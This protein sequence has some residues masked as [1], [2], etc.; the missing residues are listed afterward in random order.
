MKHLGTILSGISLLILII[1]FNSKWGSI[2]PLGKLLSPTHGYLI[3]PELQGI[4]SGF[5]M[6]ELGG[7][8]D[9]V[10][11]YFDDRMVPHIFA[12]NDEDAYFVQGYLHA[13][14]RLWQMEFQTHFAAG[15][16]SEIVGEKALVVDRTN[17]RLGMVYAAEKSLEEM[18]KDTLSF[19]AMNAYTAGVN[20]YIGTLEEKDLPL[21]YKILDYQPEPWS[22]LKSAL[23]SKYMAKDLAGY[24]DDFE[25]TAVIATMGKEIFDL[26]YPN[27]EDS[28]DP[29]IPKAFIPPFGKLTIQA[30]HDSSYFHPPMP[31]LIEREKPDKANGSNNWAL[32]GSKTMTGRPILCNDPHLKLRLPSIWYEIQ[33]TTPEYSCYGVSIPGA[34]GILIGFNEYVAFGSTNAMR[35]VMDYYEITFRD[36][37][38]SQ[39]LYNGRWESTSSRIETYVIRDAKTQADTVFYTHFGPVVYDENFRGLKN[40]HLRSNAGKFYA[41][42]WKAHDP[43]NDIVSF[44]LLDRAKNYD[45]YRKAIARFSCPGQNLIFASASGDIAITQQGVF[46]A[47][48]RYQGEFIMEGKDSLYEWQ[49]MIPQDQVLTMKNPERGFVSSANQLPADPKEYP[50]FLGGDY[51]YER[52]YRINQ[53]LR[54]L[55]KA[56][57]QD[58]IDLQND[59][60]NIRAHQIRGLLIETLK[61]RNFTNE[62]DSYFHI[63]ERWNLY[64]DSASEGAT[65]YSLLMDRLEQRIWGDELKKSQI[66]SMPEHSTLIQNLL[67][68]INF[69]CVDN[70]L[71]PQVET[72][73]E[74]LSAA[75]LSIVPVLDELKKVGRLTWGKYKQTCVP[76]LMDI[77]QN[78]SS[79]SRLDLNVGGGDGIVNATKKSHGPSWKMIVSLTSPVEAWGV[80]PGGQSGHPGNPYYDTGVG[81]W[82]EGKYFKL[83]FMK[84]FEKGS[85]KII[86]TLVFKP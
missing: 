69:A 18:E 44:L 16:L 53:I 9:S 11:V 43:S 19:L 52:G 71:T 14:D 4:Q 62:A 30:V 59:N 86:Q 45:D 39:Y 77:K 74:Q 51:V 3:D 35:D 81:P 57:V 67:R 10:Q 82:S 8:K 72:F 26:M 55:Q 1:L 66:G 49:G 12:S 76:H 56:T 31:D 83:W 32:A 23:L 34:P 65:V 50:Y 24:D 27:R 48:W 64:N 15:R 36:K 6:V 78:M 25:R 29:I 60:F 61:K 38:K 54:K 17:R 46:P 79:L 75:F 13:R 73:D 80:Y 5:S 22:N 47:K 2:P 42:R 20:S 68:N 70:V 85:D 7:L 37:S 40:D 41:V 63:L 21:E 84:P 28:L 58:M 33:I